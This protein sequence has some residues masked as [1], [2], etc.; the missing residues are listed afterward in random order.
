METWRREMTTSTPSRIES[1]LM[2]QCTGSRRFWRVRGVLE[3]PAAPR[4]LPAFFYKP[5]FT[6]IE[7]LVTI[8]IIVLIIALAIPV[9]KVL[10]GN[11]S[12]E[13]AQN[14]VGALMAEARAE[15]MG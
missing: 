4:L 3:G 14:Q 11:R 15:A 10:T 5:A 2:R 12:I 1:E 9:V 7:L 8:G 6:L 13:A